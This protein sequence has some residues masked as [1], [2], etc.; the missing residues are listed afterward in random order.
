MSVGNRAARVV[1]SESLAPFEWLS[2][3]L[4]YH[5]QAKL[6]SNEPERVP[7]VDDMVRPLRDRW[8]YVICD[9]LGLEQRVSFVGI[10][11][12][13]DEDGNC[14][15]AE[16]NR[17][18]T[19]LSP[20]LK[21][22][23]KIRPAG[24]AGPTLALPM[25]DSKGHA[26]EIRLLFSEY[27][28]P[29]AVT[30]KIGKSRKIQKAIHAAI[31]PLW[32]WE[33]GENELATLISSDG[34]SLVETP[35]YFSPTADPDG[36]DA[37][38]RD[39][40]M[41][42]WVGTDPFTIVKNCSDLYVDAR[43]DYL[44]EFQPTT[45]SGQRIVART[46]LAQTILDA[47]L[48]QDDARARYGEY[49]R[50]TALGKELE[51][52]AGRRRR[53]VRAYEARAAA[54][55]KVLDDDLF[56][57]LVT[58]SLDSELIEGD[59][60]S[61]PVSSAVEALGVAAR[62]LEES[63]FGRAL[64]IEWVSRAETRPSH[65]LNEFVLSNTTV[66]ISAF[67]AF[68]WGSKA[69]A[70][71]V[72][73]TL[74]HRAA[75]RKVTTRLQVAELLEPAVR[76]AMPNHASLHVVDIDFVAGMIDEVEVVLQKTKLSKKTKVRVPLPAED[77]F[78]MVY[79]WGEVDELTTTAATKRFLGIRAV[80]AMML[81]GV[82]VII[83]A[84]K[85]A[86]AEGSEAQT[87]A[88]WSTATAGIGMARSVVEQALNWKWAK[89][90]F[91]I[92]EATELGAKRVLTGVGVLLTMYYVR[93]NTK[94]AF[95]AFKRGDN[96]HGFALSV[97][98]AAEFA[99]LVSELYWIYAPAS[100]VAPWVVVGA[101]AVAAGAYV[102]AEL[103]KND[104]LAEFLKRCEW[105][106]ADYSALETALPYN[107][108]PAH[109]WDKDMNY[110]T[111]L[112]VRLLVRMRAWWTFETWPT[113][114]VAWDIQNPTAELEVEWAHTY[115]DGRAGTPLRT[116]LTEDEL[117]WKA[118]HHLELV[119]RL[120]YNTM[121]GLDEVTLTLRYRPN[122]DAP[123]TELKCLIMKSGQG[124]TSGFEGRRD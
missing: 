122:I 62:R 17:A 69:L 50:V 65:L 109:L 76:L 16:L 43:E 42:V 95:A 70:S 4:G 102:A 119:P 22:G 100:L 15:F 112:L 44:R 27:R 111:V 38:P 32:G 108:R 33:K 84:S 30:K 45:E 98:S 81:D 85:L 63:R 75:L 6:Q 29:S 60:R 72:K 51:R 56:Q 66:H 121:S 120:A 101:A 19:P 115:A 67:K 40:S 41:R 96:D 34:Y 35:L 8:V 106:T 88:Q 78:H 18:V 57:L 124:K 13:V 58:A 79:E 47:I 49:V 123:H 53:L 90:R 74:E 2:R 24:A 113:V 64:Y 21:R 80:G 5:P 36:D 28:L 104:P 61:L 31:A 25:T 11:I 52:I 94:G 3:Y 9:R 116:T 87:A 93:Q 91:G 39:E 54:L 7:V 83:A 89:A 55:C 14:F 68:R 97:A 20:I 71:I 110:Q 1:L 99:A 37:A 77:V 10:E 114:T 86:E 82:N 26:M 105:G 117:N 23:P 92:T 118:P 59:D 73:T 12:F 48:E 107:D 46:A 103:T